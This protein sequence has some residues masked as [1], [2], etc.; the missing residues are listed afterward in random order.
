MYIFEGRW[1]EAQVWPKE[2]FNLR[3]KITH[4]KNASVSQLQ[5]YP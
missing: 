2:T 1:L 3:R 5:T 4:S